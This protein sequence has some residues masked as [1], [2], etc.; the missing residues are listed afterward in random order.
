MSARR[1]KGPPVSIQFRDKILQLSLIH[2]S[3]DEIASV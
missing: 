1:S 2:G 3:Q